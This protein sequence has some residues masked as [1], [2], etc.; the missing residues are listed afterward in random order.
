MTPSTLDWHNLYECRH[1]GGWQKRDPCLVATRKWP[2]IDR[3]HVKGPKNGQPFYCRS[4]RISV[5]GGGEGATFKQML[6]EA[7]WVPK[8]L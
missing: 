2:I 4:C 3:V 5:W 6:S 7:N 1:I 8:Q